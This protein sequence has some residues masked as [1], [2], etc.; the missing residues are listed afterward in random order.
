[1]ATAHRET[2]EPTISSDAIG[3]LDC[4]SAGVEELVYKLAE[5]TARSRLEPDATV[6]EVNAD[7]IEKAADFLVQIIRRSDVPAQVK[8]TVDA[9]L[10]CF[11][12][13]NTHRK[14]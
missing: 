14:Q 1:M 12:H 6:I 2:K 10:Q 13:R 7:D 5:H 11:L 3:L 8:P 9:M 4:F